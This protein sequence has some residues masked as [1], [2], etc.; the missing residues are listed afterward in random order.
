MKVPSAGTGAVGDPIRFSEVIEVARYLTLAD[1]GFTIPDPSTDRHLQ[2]INVPGVTSEPAV[3]FF[4]TKQSGSVT[5][6]VRLNAQSVLQGVTSVSGAQHSW[7]EV[8]PAGAL[9]ETA[10]EL[11]FSVNGSGSV[12]FSD[13]VIL[14]KSSHLTM[15]RPIVLQA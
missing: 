15:K 12:F 8:L 11:T 2:D 3:L 1:S 5:F 4:R 9:K 6:S 14:Y 7:H 13:I 10:N